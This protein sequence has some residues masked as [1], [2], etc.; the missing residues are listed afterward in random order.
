MII[1]NVRE[2]R[3]SMS[4]LLFMRRY[5][6]SLSHVTPIYPQGFETYKNKNENDIKTRMKMTRM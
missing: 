3:Q 6:N 5:R 2:C 1:L 4:I